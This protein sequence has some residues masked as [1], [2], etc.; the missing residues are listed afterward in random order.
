MNLEK[1][2][3]LKKQLDELRPL[4]Q[5][6]LDNLEKWFEIELTYSSNALEG[7]TLTRMETSI[8]LEKGFTVSGK[9]LKDHLEAVNHYDALL[10]IKKMVGS[11]GFTLDQILYIHK[12]ILKGIED[13]HAGSIRTIPVRISGS[14]VV[15]PNYVKV[16]QLL[17]NFVADIDASKDHPVKIAAM[18]HYNLVSIHPFIDGNGR[19]ARL[20]MNLILLQSGYPPV[21]IHPK[22]RL[23]Y[24]KSLEKAQMGGDITDYLNLVYKAVQN[25]FTI[26]LK[27]LKNET[28][29]QKN[30]SSL[31]KIGELSKKTEESVATLRYWT[32]IGLLEV[33]STTTSG[34]QLYDEAQ[35][36]RSKKI[37]NLQKERYN[38]EE[39]LKLIDDSH[40]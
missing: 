12:L 18:A 7:N 19:T 28:L 24:L 20:L 26:Y 32:K 38:L 37:R 21:I 13:D 25:S 6:V 16:P 39:I 23:K 9:P 10:C 1:L 11:K 2:T 27:A 34:Y 14:A 31:M 5:E 36:Y 17:K 40:T 3:D 30:I 8:V 33:K 22:N 35:I 29:P 15:L 4:K